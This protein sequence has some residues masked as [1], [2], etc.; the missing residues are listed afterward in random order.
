MNFAS[1]FFI[2]IFL[3][4]ALIG[5]H[6][7]NG[8]GKYRAAQF[9]MLIMSLYFYAYMDIHYLPVILVSICFHYV[10]FLMMRGRTNFALPLLVLGIVFDL[11]CLFY[12]KY[13]NFFIDS[14]NAVFKADW[15][16]RE[17]ILPLGIS[18]ITFQQIAFTVDTY[19]GK[20]K[21][22]SFLEYAV[23]ISF[24]PH[25]M[26][27]PVITYDDFV[28]LLR[29]ENRRRLNWD[30]FASGLYMF[31]MG[32]GKKVLLAD[33]FG[34]A[35]DRGYGNIS[36][37]NTTTAIFITFAYTIC[38]YFDFSG[39]SDMA[40]GISRMFN[41]DLPINFNSPYKSKTIIE[42]WDRWHITLTKFLTKYIY[43]PLG[44]NRRGEVRMMVN[45]MIVFVLSGFWHGASWTFV[46]WGFLHGVFLLFTKK[47]KKV[48]ERIPSALSWLITM[49][50]VNAA[51]ILF[52]AGNFGTFKQMCEV[53]LSNNWGAL[54]KNICNAFGNFILKGIPFIPYWSG[55]LLYTVISIFI[56]LKCDNVTKRA[57]KLRLSW[58][59]A[60][61]V[62]MVFVVSLLSFSSVSTYIY[63][64]F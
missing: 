44:G 30:N 50:F 59:N 43:I 3:P 45:T 60:I 7:I 53:L 19:K 23:F 27:G 12:F 63:A 38:I 8:I 13:Y 37:L 35:A 18:F 1:Y 36:A 64:N 28:P 32:L 52:R 4:I 24:F 31:V 62:I 49:L 10:V 47:F 9:F 17:I 51:W 48:F 42:F 55:I 20:I 5:Y 26:S 58:Q 33:V 15:A 16:I 40:V 41:L 34:K 22:C 14:M 2:L 21:T 11:G 25:L 56:I 6:T 46:L 39:Y 57:E 29:D 54:N 61:F